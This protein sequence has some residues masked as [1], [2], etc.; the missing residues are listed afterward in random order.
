MNLSKYFDTF[1]D[2]ENKKDF[3]KGVILASFL[4]LLIILNILSRGY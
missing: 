1:W 4:A 2:I 3:F